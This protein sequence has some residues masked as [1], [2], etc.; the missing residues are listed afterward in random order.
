MVDL[1]AFQEDGFRSSSTSGIVMGHPAPWTRM[2]ELPS[3]RRW[4]LRKQEGHEL[5]ADV[6]ASRK[7][8]CIV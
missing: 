1:T 6:T 2:D 7:S 3:I 5:S 8:A 4:G